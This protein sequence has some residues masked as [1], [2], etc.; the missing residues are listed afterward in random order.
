MLDTVIQDFKGNQYF[1]PKDSDTLFHLL[2][3]DYTLS[4]KVSFY[5]KVKKNSSIK[6]LSLTEKDVNLLL[7][8]LR[9]EGKSYVVGFEKEIKASINK[10]SILFTS[11]FEVPFTFSLL[12][13]EI[14]KLRELYTC[15]KQQIRLYKKNI[16]LLRKY[17]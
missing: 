2:I 14:I 17:K 4:C 12:N 11:N 8:H 7:K 9:E 3:D 5:K 10:D 6:G 15:G 13:Y 16:K 1:L